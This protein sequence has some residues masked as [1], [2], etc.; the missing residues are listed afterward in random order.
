MRLHRRN[1]VHGDGFLSTQ[2]PVIPGMIADGVPSIEPVNN[3][4]P[5]GFTN[6][7]VTICYE[8]IT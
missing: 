1:Q 5:M 2:G 8:T 7:I 4:A 6:I 3:N